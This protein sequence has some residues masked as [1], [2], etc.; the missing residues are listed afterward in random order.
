M[1]KTLIL[2][3]KKLRGL[4]QGSLG[5][6]WTMAL[7]LATLL[8]VVLA[9]APETVKA[10][11][12]ASLVL[13]LLLA[14]LFVA[15]CAAGLAA[16][17]LLL[18]GKSYGKASVLATTAWLVRTSASL[19]VLTGRLPSSMGFALTVTADAILLLGVLQFTFG[20]LHLKGPWSLW[21]PRYATLPMALFFVGA[22]L[23]QSMQSLGQSAAYSGIVR[24]LSIA[25]S[26]AVTMAA[27][28]YWPSLRLDT[29]SRT[30]SLLLR[31]PG[32]DQPR[33][34]S[35][36]AVLLV[37]TLSNVLGELLGL[38]LHSGPTT[39]NPWL[40]FF[41]APLAMLAIV[42]RANSD[43]KV[44]SHEQKHGL[45][46]AQMTPKSAQ[47]FLRRYLAEGKAWAA[48]VG[49]KSSTYT[50]DH[51]LGGLLHQELP[52]TIMQIRAEEIQRCINEV[53]QTLSL[54]HQMVEHRLFG[55]IDPEVSLRPCIDT[56]KMFATL[57][58]DA[59]P[60]VERRIKGLSALLPIIDK[61]L[62]SVL[63]KKNLDLLN[64]QNLWF[65]HFD[66]GWIDQH[67]I[68]TPKA[69]KYDIRLAGL[70][71]HTLASLSKH[72]EK[73]G[74]ISNHIWLGPEARERLV[75]EAPMLRNIIETNP[76][77]D[78]QQGDV[79]LMF[80]LRFEN[81]IPRLQ[82]YF[83]LD[84]FRKAI[85]DF[86]PTPERI[87][88]TGLLH[89]KIQATHDHAGLLAVLESIASVP[90]SGFKE[91]DAAL[92][93]VLGCYQKL[94]QL[95]QKAKAEADASSYLDAV[96]NAVEK[97]GY[98]S[99]IL[100]AAQVQKLA[101]RDFET[102]R[103]AAGNPRHARF[104]EAWVLLGSYD[105]RRLKAEQL[106]WLV[107]FIQEVPTRT[108]LVQRPLVQ[109]KLLDAIGGLS[110]VAQ[111]EAASIQAAL[112]A[113]AASLIR[114]QADPDLICH[115]LDTVEFIG[116]KQD[117]G[118]Q[119]QLARYVQVLEK[120]LGT[121]S[122]RLYGIKSRWRQGESAKSASR[123]A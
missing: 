25:A 39:I 82:R 59:G 95:G 38:M 55:S 29:H 102:L 57:Y 2:W 116:L 22:F 48:T 69:T 7:V 112:Q 53:L 113:L 105:F 24:D 30:R 65:F 99:Q 66:F 46:S 17:C 67:I 58:L 111:S 36:F 120:E 85:L 12:E 76:I 20:M 114:L 104:N 91:K 27:L 77:P 28:A 3:T 37:A 90:W 73:K 122:P 80:V 83:D 50:I 26:L 70:T 45:I 49:L 8:T 71:S 64:R 92:T 94:G 43:L 4:G 96:I 42:M 56:L 100:H 18:T 88:L 81:L 11:Q 72:M 16:M 1:T 9:F 52:T 101:L 61:G 93:L 34:R 108:D 74:G 119:A 32:N 123:V 13:S 6:V 68:H 106:T 121:N 89:N 35:I 79:A 75:Q 87:R 19:S 109:A 117:E 15:S 31:L 62:A 115:Y 97:I 84:T 5:R 63:A 54:S 21:P 40:V 86:D 44:H 110:R 47:R 41:E 23:S 98:P 103:V 78:E 33:E 14:Q 10:W 60:L 107:S 51:D 118:L